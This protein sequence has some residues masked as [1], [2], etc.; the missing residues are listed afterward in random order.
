VTAELGWALR[1][2]LDLHVYLSTNPRG[3]V[4]SKPEDLPH[5][6]WDNLLFGNYDESRT[7]S[8]DVNF[9]EARCIFDCVSMYADRQFTFTRAF[10]REM[11]RSGRISF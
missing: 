1:Q 6:V 4:F 10:W 2:P 11:A 9:P 8:Y 7:V 3:D 5:F